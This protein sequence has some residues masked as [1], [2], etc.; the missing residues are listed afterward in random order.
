[1]ID[2][3]SKDRKIGIYVALAII[4]SV[5]ILYFLKP[6]LTPFFIAAFL[7]YI[8][9]PLVNR[10]MRIKLP[11]SLAVTLVFTVIMLGVIAFFVFFIPL[12]GR[13]I[14]LLAKR[15]PDFFAWMDQ[16]ILPLLNQHLGTN[17]TLDTQSLK[18]VLT[19]HWQQAGNIAALAWSTLSHSGLVV[20]SWLA[21]LVLIPVVTFYL[22]R[23]W[24]N[25]IKNIQQLLPRRIESYITH[26]FVEFDEVLSAFFRGQFLVMLGLTIIYAVGLTIAGL[27]LALLLAIVAGVLAIVPYLGI[28]VGILSAGIA[29]F[30]Q[31]HDWIHVLY[32]FIVFLIGH[33]IE[34]IVLT[35]WLLGNRIGLH[36]VA[37]IFA[38]LAGG[39]LF[40]FMGILL[41]LPV[42]AIIMVVIRHLKRHYLESD[43]YTFSEQ[44][45]E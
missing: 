9:D 8:G 30:M 45:S 43:L 6:V 42:A 39:H 29:A 1:M 12:L 13:Q 5:A 20:L 33:L 38:I 19:Q 40:G 41:A 44:S 24:G 4:V 31:F 37:V 22:L 35:P 36:P 11:R 28:I 25:L 23:D 3:I 26:L 34:N 10:L 32:V 16:V 14:S 27:D 17:L 21:N 2:T 15:L 18:T 7:A